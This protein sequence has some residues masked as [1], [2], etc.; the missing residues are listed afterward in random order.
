MRILKVPY[1]DSALS[2]P[3]CKDGP[4]AV[5][6]QLGSGFDIVEVAYPVDREGQVIIGGS[7]CITIGA[8]KTFLKDNPNAGMIIFDAH[9][10]AYSDEDLLPTLI[11]EGLDPNKLILVGVRNKKGIEFARQKGIQ[12]IDMHIIF[13]N[14]VKNVCDGIMETSKN[15]PALYVSIDIDVVDPAFAPGTGTIEPGG[16]SSR[17]MIYFIQRLKKM[18]N[19]SMVDIVEIDPTIDV[20][21]MTSKLG[22]K[23]I[24]ELC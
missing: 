6:K 9:I 20:N 4:G 23:L 19:L 10:D 13:N 12:I 2:S 18:K 3:G 17:E 15:W 14:G 8:F 7:H 22:A 21:N 5:V 16:I 24:K 1:S 11:K